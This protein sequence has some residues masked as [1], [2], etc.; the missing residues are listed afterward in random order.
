MGCNIFPDKLRGRDS[1]SSCDPCTCFVFYLGNNQTIFQT[2]E[3]IHVCIVIRIYIYTHTRVT[4]LIEI[5][6]SNSHGWLP[7][8]KTAKK[9]V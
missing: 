2:K 1:Q 6:F 4:F 9:Y 8:A 5:R 3:N 7:R